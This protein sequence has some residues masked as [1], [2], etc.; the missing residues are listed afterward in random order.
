MYSRAMWCNDILCIHCSVNVSNASR[1][2]DVRHVM[3]PA[4]R[5]GVGRTAIFLLVL[6][7]GNCRV[8]LP[9]PA[10][11]R[12]SDARRRVLKTLV[13]C[14]DLPFFLLTKRERN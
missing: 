3:H 7:G 2:R 11:Q 5:K 10:W 8:S 4:E 14:D 1:T 12:R 9:L 6:R 13:M